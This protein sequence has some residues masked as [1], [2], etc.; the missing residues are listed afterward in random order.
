MS[1]LDQILRVKTMLLL[2]RYEYGPDGDEIDSDSTEDSW[3][4]E[5]LM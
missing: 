1:V 3:S 5:E 4:E 2:N